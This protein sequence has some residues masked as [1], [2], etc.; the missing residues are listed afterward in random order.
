MR[1]RRSQR[2]EQL[3]TV[4]GFEG[5][6]TE[7]GQRLALLG[8]L[9]TQLGEPC[10]DPLAIHP[11][12]DRLRERDEAPARRSQQRQCGSEFAAREP[13]LG[14]GRLP[15]RIGERRGFGATRRPGGVHCGAS[16]LQR[17][18]RLARPRLRVAIA[19]GG[20]QLAFA[21]RRARCDLALELLHRAERVLE[22]GE[23][24]GRSAVAGLWRGV[25][26][27]AHLE[28][29]VRGQGDVCRRL[30]GRETR[31]ETLRQLGGSPG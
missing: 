8:R 21:L 29:A 22:A 25:G 27:P 4:R 1:F 26:Q 10:F 13:A 14:A 6:C 31:V 12:G 2:G 9:R 24:I 15:G 3:A 28:V 18:E 11:P 20:L 7:R 23:R 16:V 19:F 30:D 5:G 17:R